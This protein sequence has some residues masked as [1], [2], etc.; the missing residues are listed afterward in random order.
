MEQI[1]LDNANDSVLN[2]VKKLLGD[3]PENQHFDMDIMIYINGA[4]TRLV[5]LGLSKSS[6]KDS[7]ATWGQIFGDRDDLED[8][9]NYVYLKV[10]LI[11]DPPQTQFLLEAINK[12]IAEL[13]WLFSVR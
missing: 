4:L 10:R 2:T 13:E 8:V 3:Q 6:I 5:D 9:K 7:E 1:V 11:F 12:Q